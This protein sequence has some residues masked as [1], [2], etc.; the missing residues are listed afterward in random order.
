[1]VRKWESEPDKD[2]SAAVIFC[3]NIQEHPINMQHFARYEKFLTIVNPL[4]IVRLS[5][6]NLVFLAKLSFEHLILHT[7]GGGGVARAGSWSKSAYE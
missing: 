5:F 2:F 6:Q 3:L 7:N 1:M 4:K